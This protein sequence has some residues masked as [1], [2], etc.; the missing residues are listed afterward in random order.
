VRAASRRYALDWLV[1]VKGKAGVMGSRTFQTIEASEKKLGVAF[2]LPSS[3]FMLIFLF[4]PIGYSIYMSLFQWKLFDLGRQKSFVGLANFIR[5]FS[6]K[7]FFNAAVNTLLIVGVCLIAE[8]VLGFFIALALWS[9]QKTSKI[10]H[11]I[12][13]LPMIISPVI[14]CL[15]LSKV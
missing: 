4:V 10:V 15:T 7:L 12:I 11:S 13:L 9:I 6:D 14:G 2:L 5:A 8:I 1:A 3:V